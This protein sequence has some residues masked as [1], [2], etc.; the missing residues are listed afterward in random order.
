MEYK[1]VFEDYNNQGAQFLSRFCR[2]LKLFY[3]YEENEISFYWHG[4]R[5]IANIVVTC[6]LYKW[7]KDSA[8]QKFLDN[9]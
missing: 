1:V 5:Y 6:I 7:F 9:L 4:I 2:K 3:M 8:L